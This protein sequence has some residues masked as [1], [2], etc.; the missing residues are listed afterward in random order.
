SRVSTEMPVPLK[1][2]RRIGK[3][4]TVASAGASSICV[5]MMVE[6]LVDMGP[7]CNTGALWSVGSAESGVNPWAH[8]NAWP[9]P[10]SSHQDVGCLSR[11]VR[12][13]LEAEKLP[14]ERREI[15]EVAR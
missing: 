3:S 7:P 9:R 4:E 12:Q 6:V 8:G 11:Q 15:D 10:R 2:A 5:Q 1:N 13:R 14:Q